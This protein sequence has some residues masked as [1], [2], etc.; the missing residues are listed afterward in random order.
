[1]RAVV[2]GVLA[3]VAATGPTPV[4][5]QSTHQSGPCGYDL[6]GDGLVSTNDLLYILAVFGRQVAED[7]SFGIADGN[8]D[9]LI[10]TQDLLGLLASFGRTCE[11]LTAP[12]P[13]PPITPE[14]A[15]AEF[16]AVLAAIAEDPTA[17]LVA[18]ASAI[19]F[20]GDITMVAEGP[21][22]AEF[23]ASFTSNMAAS[24][25]DGA[26]NGASA[27]HVLAGEG[28]ANRGGA[29]GGQ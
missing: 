3:L 4:S 11:D 23:E 24:I 29:G 28:A 25:G 12:P 6:N 17:P 15:A 16:E 13:P 1:M 21:A 8:G 2:G 10:N 9:G 18:I 14:A 5:A 7:S 22:R 27:R 19:T 20:E 26:Q